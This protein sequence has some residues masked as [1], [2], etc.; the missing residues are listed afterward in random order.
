MIDLPDYGRTG[1][2]RSLLCALL[3]LLTVACLASCGPPA[4]RYRPMPPPLTGDA[5]C[6]DPVAQCM[7]S[8]GVCRER[9]LGECR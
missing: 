2:A 4:V 3:L 8:S 7:T 9:R 5:A 1:P 6:S